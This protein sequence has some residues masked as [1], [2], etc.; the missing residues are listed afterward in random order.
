MNDVTYN[1]HNCMVLPRLFSLGVAIEHFR[2][3]TNKFLVLTLDVL[4]Y[5]SSKLHLSS[6]VD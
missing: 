1:L 4:K 5:A 6:V 3:C 2:L